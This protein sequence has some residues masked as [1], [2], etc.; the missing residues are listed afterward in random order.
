ML[1]FPVPH[2]NNSFSETLMMFPAEKLNNEPALPDRSVG[3]EYVCTPL[4]H[5][6]L[7][8][9]IKAQICFLTES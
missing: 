5:T 9:L 3:L 2:E 6:L 1:A 7:K 8:G 4:R